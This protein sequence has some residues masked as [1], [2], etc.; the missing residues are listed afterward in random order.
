MQVSATSF[1][2]YF[3]LLKIIIP[4]ASL[5]LNLIFA[6]VFF[7]YK[8]KKDDREI[9]R[10]IKLDWFN[11]LILDYNLKFF[12]E[13]F[14]NVEKAMQD[15]SSTLG[16]EASKNR[17]GEE[18]IKSDTNEKINEFHTT[19]RVKF[20]DSLLAVDPSIYDNLIKVSDK[21]ID[22]FTNSI[23]D[24]GINL[25]HPPMFNEKVIKL[26]SQTKTSMIEE[27]FKFDG[28]ASKKTDY[29][30]PRLL[31]SGRTD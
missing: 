11:T 20:I 24:P 21:M 30:L 2:L 1:N 12:H 9:E 6:L 19:L 5:V 3:E 15:L 18:A 22:S 17:I 26:L 29:K 27:L 10:K 23:F 4:V 25:S 13:F 31:K 28:R 7:I 16:N 14:E 8:N